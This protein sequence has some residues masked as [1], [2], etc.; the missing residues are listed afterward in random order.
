M[1]VWSLVFLVIALIAGLLGFGDVAGAAS[2]AARLLFG[3]FLLVFLVSLA[4]YLL[5]PGG[6][7][8]L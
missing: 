3:V 2:G 8:P 1:I 4:M 7:A 5:R 6:P